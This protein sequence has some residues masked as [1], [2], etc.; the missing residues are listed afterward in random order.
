MKKVF[1]GVG[2]LEGVNFR[3]RKGIQMFIRMPDAVFLWLSTFFGCLLSL[4]FL[5]QVIFDL[6]DEMLPGWVWRMVWL[7]FGISLNLYVLMVTRYL[8]KNKARFGG[9]K[10]DSQTIHLYQH[11]LPD[12]ED[13]LSSLNSSDLKKFI[14]AT[15]SQDLLS[16]MNLMLAQNA[17]KLYE[18]PKANEKIQ[19]RDEKEL[20]DVLVGAN[21][22]VI[23]WVLEEKLS[24]GSENQVSAILRSLQK[25]KKSTTDLIRF[26]RLVPRPSK[27][28]LSRMLAA[29]AKNKTQLPE[30]S[31]E[32]Q[33]LLQVNIREPMGTFMNELESLDDKRRLLEIGGYLSARDFVFAEWFIYQELVCVQGDLIKEFFPTLKLIISGLKARDLIPVTPEISAPFKKVLEHNWS[34]PKVERLI[35]QPDSF[36]KTL[37]QAL[38]F[39]RYK[40]VKEVT[41]QRGIASEDQ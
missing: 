16:Y 10:S 4:I 8:T 28:D 6:F 38:E 31:Q 35:S 23:D 37:F 40:D 34:D 20:V 11:E 2:K 33:D 36:R 24:E 7:G 1:N 25:S 30:Y 39:D 9:A 17:L 29:L 21:I 27:Q 19:T 41:K 15:N 3:I 18:S 26:F 32:I 14:K 5:P 22:Q 12:L 13:Y